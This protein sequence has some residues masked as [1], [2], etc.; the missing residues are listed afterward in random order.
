MSSQCTGP[1]AAWHLRCANLT[2]RYSTRWDELPI[3]RTNLGHLGQQVTQLNQRLMGQHQ[4]CII[5]LDM[6]A[7]AL[8]PLAEQLAELGGTGPCQ[9]SEL[10]V[11]GARCPG[12]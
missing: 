8:G 3:A 10:G 9:A 2:Q 12:R 7:V 1:G 11:G 5:Q 6:R 4:I